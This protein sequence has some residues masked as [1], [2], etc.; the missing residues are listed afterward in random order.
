MQ[1]KK[2]KNVVETQKKEKAEGYQNKSF[3]FKT[4]YCISSQHLT[5][6]TEH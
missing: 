1:T 6:I 4:F 5:R 3:L 2:N